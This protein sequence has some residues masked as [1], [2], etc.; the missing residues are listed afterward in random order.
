MSKTKYYIGIDPGVHTGLAIWDADGREFVRVETIGI[1]AAMV[2]IVCCAYAPSTILRD[3]ASARFGRSMV[4]T[5]FDSL[6]LMASTSTLSG[7]S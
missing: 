6:A 4:R 3:L 5:P 2:G 1:V 7:I